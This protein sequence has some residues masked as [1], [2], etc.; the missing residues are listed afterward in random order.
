MHV[1]VHARMCV[2]VCVCVCVCV[3]GFRTP[4]W[5]SSHTRWQRV[6][7]S[8]LLQSPYFLLVGVESPPLS[9]LNRTCVWIYESYYEGSEK[10]A[11]RGK[12][13]DGQM[14]F[15]P[16]DV[17]TLSPLEKHRFNCYKWTVVVLKGQFVKYGWNFRWKHWKGT[18][19]QE[20]VRK[21]PQ[22]HYVK[23]STYCVYWS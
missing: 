18:F 1:C 6:R 19:Y 2:R 22:W 10:W 8:D 5:G 23:M 20:N 15:L 7:K 3:C 16:E 9:E 21:Q 4:L 12:K 11:K 17:Q 14:D 13:E